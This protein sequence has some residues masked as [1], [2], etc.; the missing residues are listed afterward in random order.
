M[1]MMNI[2]IS[3]SSSFIVI[4]MIVIVIALQLGYGDIII[5]IFIIIIRFMSAFFK[6]VPSAAGLKVLKTVANGSYILCQPLACY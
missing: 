3:S 5:M 2:I 4:M 6:S 1:M